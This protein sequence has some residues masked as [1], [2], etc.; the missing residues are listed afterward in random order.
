V[1]SVLPADQDSVPPA[2]YKALIVPP[3]R[4][5][6]WLWA[7]IALL[8]I[9][10]VWAYRYWKRPR[11]IASVSAGPARP[12]WELAHEALNALEARG[13]HARGE[14]RPFAIELSEITRRY[15]E[16]RF[17]FVALE[18][19]TREIR[20]ALQHTS[21][22]DSQRDPLLKTLTDCDLAKYAKFHWPAPELVAALRTVRTF[23]EQTTPRVE[24]KA[25]A[26]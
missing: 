23:V 3:R 1:A 11:T 10:A 16:H 9:A 6:V 25:E 15:L 18:Q 17:G 2:D 24:Q 20:A 12:P 14:P 4:I 13:Y 7:T 21:T 8:A 5:P 22:H 19:T 26:V